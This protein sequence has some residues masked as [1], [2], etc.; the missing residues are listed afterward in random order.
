MF[1]D[2]GSTAE[3]I[4]SGRTAA[5]LT[6]S[7]QDP[8][9]AEGLQRTLR[10]RPEVAQW[11]TD[12]LTELGRI[13]V[14]EPSLMPEMAVA[15]IVAEEWL[16]NPDRRWT[17]GERSNGSLCLMGSA[18]AHLAATKALVEEVGDIITPAAAVAGHSGGLASAWAVA[19]HGSEIPARVGAEVMAAMGLLG[20]EAQKH[21]ESVRAKNLDAVFAGEDMATPMLAVAGLTE[22]RLIAE[23][24]T[25]GTDTVRIA[26]QNCFDRFVLTGRPAELSE[27]ASDLSDADGVQCE[28]IPSNVG[29]HH[30]WLL[31]NARDMVASLEHAGIAFA[32]D[33]S[34]TLIDPRDNTHH[35]GGDLTVRIIES[36]SCH[37]V[38]W[39]TFVSE[40][41]SAGD[42]VIDVGP[43]A[44][45]GILSRRTLRGSGATVILAG[46]TEGLESLR[47]ADR[48]P[49]PLLNYRDFLPAVS[50]FCDRRVQ[51][52]HTL[53]TG[54]S[55]FILAGM[56][57]TTTD[58]AIVAAAANSG[59]V[60]EI[61]G[62]GQVS[63]FIF[64]ER[65]AE[66]GEL[67]NTGHEV[68]FN[69]L[70]LD[71][72]LWG[73]HLG[74]DRLVQKARRG[75]APINGVTI[76]A[77]IPEA[78]EA[79]QLLDELNS[80]GIWLNAFKPGTRAQVKSLLEIAS[81]TEHN[82]WVHLEGGRAGGHHSWVDLEEL[83]FASYNDL[84]LHDNLTICVG[85][86]IGSAE[87]AAEFLDGTWALRHGAQPMPV[88]AILIGTAAMAT[89]ESTASDGVKQLLVSAPGVDS[90]VG[91]GEVLGGCTS[92]RSGLN[93]DIHYLDNTASRVAHMLG[94]IS[95]DADAIAERHDEIAA[96]LN[97]TA[98]PWFGPLAHMT[99]ME[100]VERFVELTALGNNGR[101]EDGQ[102]LDVTHRER[103][104]V[105]LHRFE[106]RCVDADEGEF[107]SA[108]PGPGSLDDPAK[109][110]AVLA[111]RYPVAATAKL[112]A[113]D[114]AFFVATCDR[115]G[116][117]VPFVPV[118]DS[119]V[120]RRYLADSLWQS[121]SD[122][123][124]ADE[125]LVIPGPTAVSGIQ[126]ANEPVAELLARF[127]SAAS[128]A[129]DP[130]H[131]VSD[132]A[133]DPRSSRSAVEN[134]L[135]LVSVRWGSAMVPSPL[136][137]AARGGHWSIESS[138]GDADSGEV[139]ATFLEA[140]DTPDSTETIVCRGPEG[141]TGTVE[142]DYRWPA[143]RT[144]PGDGTFRFSIEVGT[145]R[146]ILFGEVLERSIDGAQRDVLAMLIEGA[147]AVAEGAEPPAMGVPTP[148]LATLWPATFEALRTADVAEGLLRLV[149]LRHEMTLD[150]PDPGAD[151]AEIT[152]DANGAAGRVI[153]TRTRSGAAT[154]V[155]TFLVRNPNPSGTPVEPTPSVP[156]GW[157]ETPV[158]HLGHRVIFAPRNPEVFAE[159]SGD[160][161]PIHRSNLLARVA[162]LPGRIVHGMWTS[163]AAQAFLVDELGVGPERLLSW[164]ID[165]MG[166]VEPG[167]RLNFTAARVAVKDARRRVEVK[168]LRGDEPVAIAHAT[169]AAARTAYVFPGQ[170]IQAQGMGL[171]AIKRCPAAKEVWQR[172]D[173]HCRAELGFSVIEVVRDNPKFL[174]VGDETFRHP[175][176]VL[177]LTQFT[178]VAMATLAAAQFAELTEAG[179]RVQDCYIA[180]H[181][182]GEYNALAAAAGVLPLEAVLGIVWARGTAMHNLVERDATGASNYRLGVVRPHLAG[183]DADAAKEL[184][185]SVADSTG[186]LCEIVNHNLRGRQ[187]AVAGTVAALEALSDA[188]GDGEQKGR[189]PFLLVPGIDVPF[190]SR[191]LE[192]GV[193]EFK[194]HLDEALPATIDPSALVGR[195]IPNLHPEPFSLEREYV[196]AVAAL[197]GEGSLGHVLGDWA[198][199]STRPE[200]LARE[201]LVEILA[202]Q[203]ASPVR[204]IETTDVLLA[205]EDSG[206]LGVEQV[207][208]IG[209]GASPTLTNLTKAAVAAENFGDVTVMN[210]EADEDTVFER[211]EVAPPP[212][213]VEPAQAGED[214]ADDPADDGDWD[215]DAPA[216]RKTTDSASAPTEAPAA[217][218]AEEPAP[219]AV[220]AAAQSTGVTPE[221]GFG[222][223]DAVEVLLA[224]ITGMRLD[225][226]GDDSIDDLVDGA[227]SRR[228]QV[229]MDMGKEFALGSVD[230]AH[231]ASRG[232]LAVRLGE[233]ARGY[234][235][236]GPV[237]STAIS[238][239]VTAVLGPLGGTDSG[240]AD[241][242]ESSW[243]IS[244]GW[245]SHVRCELALGGR[246]D[247]SRRGGELRTLGSAGSPAEAID[248]ALHAVAAR[249]GVT[250]AQPTQV[251]GATVDSAELDELA[252]RVDAAFAS[253]VGAAREALGTAEVSAAG[254]EADST[255]A[256]RLAV[257]DSEHGASRAD[258][259]APVFHETRIAVFDSG[260]AWARADL[261]H[262][263][264]GLLRGTLEGDA[265]DAMVGRLATFAGTDRRFD[266]SV[267]WYRN[268]AEALGRDD[269]SV[270]LGRIVAG[271]E[272]DQ[273]LRQSRLGGRTVLLSGASP[274]SIAEAAA[275]R[276]LASGATVILLTSS[277][278]ASRRRHVR[279]LERR[280][281]AP[282]ARAFLVGANLASFTDIDRL[283][284]WLESPSEDKPH[285]GLPD[286]VLPFAAPTVMG[287]VADTGP[288]SE[289]ELRVLLL[290]VERL[291]G[292]LAESVGTRGGGGQITAVLP[293]SPNH[294]TFG[295]DGAYGTAKA[296]LEVLE[297]RSRSEHQRWGRYCRIIGAEIGWVRGTG[298]MEANDSFAPIVEQRL[299]IKTF[300]SSEMG[301]LIAA[302]CENSDRSGRVDLT[303]GM[304]DL[305]DPGALAKLLRSDIGK[306]LP[307][308]TGV[309]ADAGEPVDGKSPEGDSAA[310]SQ[311]ETTQD[312]TTLFALVSPVT[313]PVADLAAQWPTTPELSADDMIVVCGTS[314]IGPWGTSRTRAA[315]ERSGILDAASVVELAVGCGLL[316]WKSSGSGGDWVDV[317]SDEV[318]PVEELV[319]RYREEVESRC[320]VRLS[321]QQTYE[322]ETEIFTPNPITLDLP[323]EEQAR[324]VTAAIAG[325][326]AKRTE[327]GWSV[328]L[329]KGSPIRVPRTAELPRG[330]TA[331][332][333]EG[334]SPETL[335]L[336]AELTSAVD[337]MA[338]WSMYL[339]AD[340][341]RDAG[342]D[343]EEILGAVHPSRVG[344]TQGTGMGGMRSI[345]AMYVD[346]MRGTPHANDMLQEALGNVPAAH[347][348]Q[349]YVGGYGPMVHPVAACATAAVSLEAAVDIISAD[350]ADVVVGGGLDDLGAEGIIG[351]ADMA[352]TASSVEMLEA[353]FEPSE[354]SRPGDRARAGFVEGQGGGAMLICRGSV[355]RRLGLVVKAVVGLARSHSDGVQT[356]I[357]APGLGLL[358]VGAGGS[359]SPLGEA[360]RAHGIG[361]DDIA[362]VSKHDTS[363]RANDPNEAEIHEVLQRQIGRSPGN[364]L[365][366]ISQ[367]HL[368]GHAKGGAAAWQIAG[369][370]DLF[371]TGVVPGNRNLDCVDPDVARD[372]LTV[373]DRPLQLAEVPRAAMLTSLGFGHVSAAV[374]LVH[375]AAFV[376]AL[377]EE[378]REDYLSSVERRNSET[379]HKRRWESFGGGPAYLRRKGRRL[380]G[381]GYEEIRRSEVA[382]LTDPSVRLVDGVYAAQPEGNL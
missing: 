206:G 190:H 248:E 40:T 52:R 252:A 253:A 342:T 354:L 198:A 173:K 213:A 290:G 116:K 81:R 64:S 301:D 149:H 314:E 58:A 276:L 240:V 84:R 100:V 163:H 223:G 278:S 201:L 219:A 73:M 344:N 254:D 382:A 74:K 78:D 349:S 152:S 333:P 345:R 114:V 189:D 381:A 367:K 195:Y 158:E 202:W 97:R 255:S 216:P 313:L 191:A 280:F 304:N 8:D 150:S 225:Q 297:A 227:S 267:E 292:K 33:L 175:A 317:E 203:F 242:L 88:D 69:A 369:L 50:D 79:L 241:H 357:P 226:L 266:D 205:G 143:S 4:S 365:R 363:T 28:F 355:A 63:P 18:L 105:L 77:G 129:F 251:S 60:A 379:A 209:L 321:A 179:A 325:S 65:M 271:P 212:M 197:C 170:G 124:S 257:L 53:R 98:K 47:R 296:G 228:N 274:G 70:Y 258:D 339:T 359:E 238:S 29:Y 139:V 135:E 51:T 160:F 282:G 268:R 353:G 59:N 300:S 48:V 360:L 315:V 269:I 286:V 22:P 187:Y 21:P 350:K 329:P 17:R 111:E 89:A 134:L 148:A 119:E 299:G 107:T 101:Y 136:A 91:A 316:E 36:M 140:P 272:E 54:R 20:A 57:P 347:A 49:E 154:S 126:Q 19:R 188:L 34:T 45:V 104:A 61:A 320:G 302:L 311:D 6:Y 174:T 161:N 230:G 133:F 217:V 303:G 180:G 233:L 121:H 368:T 109:A 328:T 273:Q 364:P 256:A 24:E 239:G 2:Q 15:G 113:D 352:A 199:A 13:L 200:W 41:A 291:V 127:D 264:S 373:D 115:P 178:Q 231:E 327:T 144:A 323:D 214:P 146:G 308:R 376:A 31:P 162:G 177:H 338:A 322:V 83:L 35:N 287:D 185:E 361:A 284:D 23:L 247:A 186:E 142:V 43:S 71:P 184:V 165:F 93:A 348:M 193:A 244:G 192:P 27:L 208:E 86:G 120:R 371:S 131:T 356:S 366:V 167:E 295:G 67:L 156:E 80:L 380:A 275:S 72:Y 309:Q 11:C 1:V 102:W 375:P 122:L 25:L 245:I 298:L 76:S 169:V 374:L 343:P 270:V 196:E 229:L 155:D 372:W 293:M 326:T 5:Y 137:T 319:E 237:L 106:A 159:L 87:R 218:A 260:V 204:W 42:V 145:D 263:W 341:F 172:A 346:P 66:L 246:N 128:E 318:V 68:V 16:E 285:P 378:S 110:V 281:G 262:L 7:G 46:T 194:S 232:D 44:V 224:H 168:V 103:F 39:A 157:S 377:A 249:A 123:W 207:V 12:V 358:S 95:G 330:V 9:W 112:V 235:F 336:P 334:M 211:T 289:I 75:G 265:L 312:E 171:D 38:R 90:V 82:L 3:A 324:G 164:R 351:F 26:L 96:E 30:E 176:G 277:F 332:I 288:T 181:S 331:A 215:G 279:D 182:V 210:F 85:G 220:P 99:Y 94:E 236:P 138:T 62:G 153:E 307:G 234:S 250:L 222:V 306:D 151:G 125:V 14:A 283:V 32:G 370:C 92:G 10:G 132:I 362:V 261:D 56:T 337:P 221:L 55:A 310:G 147:T 243:G 294:G 305:D 118:I 259:V 183:L 335:G 340:A 117:P 130:T 108:F 141:P 37:P 166:I